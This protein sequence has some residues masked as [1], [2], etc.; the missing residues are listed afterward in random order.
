[1]KNALL[2]PANP[3]DPAQIEGALQVG[4]YAKQ[5]L[6]V[7]PGLMLA[8]FGG[9]KAYD[10]E[11]LM[12]GNICA[13][14]AQSSLSSSTCVVM[15][16]CMPPGDQDFLNEP[17]RATEHVRLAIAFASRLDFNRRIVSFHLGS[18]LSRE[19]FRA[20]PAAVWRKSIF[21]DVAKLLSQLAEFAKKLGVEL[22][23]ETTPVPYFGDKPRGD[24]TEYRGQ[25]LR[26]LCD[27]FYLTGGWGFEQ[28]RETGCGI[29]LDLCHTFQL[30]R[31]VRDDNVAREYFFREDVEHLRQRDI[32][33]DV[34]ALDLARDIVHLNDTSGR[35]T[36]SGQTFTEG[37]TL[38]SGTLFRL[39]PLIMM[40]AA[41][42][43]PLVLELN[44][45]G[46]DGKPDYVD[47][48]GSYDSVDWLS[49]LPGLADM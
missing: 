37:V 31:S 2:I 49:G 24:E 17:A 4:K 25:R 12:F 39:K 33:R 45:I 27:P 41:M 16:H 8:T 19:D 34:A 35:F 11:D 43:I 10:Q 15:P 22:N 47:K 1:M 30:Y 38:G 32:D 46:A 14:G 7:E 42:K 5:Q 21:P 44:E 23:V 48:P 3:L 13:A 20:V 36:L 6:G 26:D 28:I 9:I 40:L 29:T 18:L